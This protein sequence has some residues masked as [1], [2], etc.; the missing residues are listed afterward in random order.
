MNIPESSC[1]SVN[2][3]SNLGA[4]TPF[5]SAVRSS[6]HFTRK[7][8]TAWPALN[9]IA[10]EMYCLEKCLNAGLRPAEDQRMH[11]MRAF[12]GVDGFKVL[13]VAHDVIFGLDAVAA[14]H[15]A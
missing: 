14:V 9:V 12:I 10:M 11:I 4:C 3:L 7:G 1:Q 15:V 13:R 5:F 2:C 8:R 6:S